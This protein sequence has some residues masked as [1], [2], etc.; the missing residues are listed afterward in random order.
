MALKRCRE[1]RKL[2]SSEA[3]VCPHCG[4]KTPV[5][6]SQ[7]SSRDVTAT[8][9][10]PA[11]RVLLWVAL[12]AG[13]LAVVLLAVRQ[14]DP[15]SE[16]DRAAIARRQADSVRV[17][18]LLTTRDRSAAQTIVLDRLRRGFLGPQNDSVHL[19]AVDA[20]LDSASRLLR[21]QP[22]SFPLLN[23]VRHLFGQLAQPLTTAQM[24]RLRQLQ[25]SER[26]ARAPLARQAERAAA[27]R[28]RQME[29]ATA[30]N[31]RRYARELEN[32]YLGQGL[33]VTVRA[34]AQNATTLRIT[35][36]LVSRPMAYQFSQS[37]T[38][39]SGLRSQGF[40]RLE[41]SDGYSQMWYWNL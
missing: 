21:Q 13:M 1:C 30:E 11:V 25:S 20:A 31:R 36:I 22:H 41:I 4:I 29:V 14:T 23:E 8:L 28:R 40:R 5:R 35:W 24:S 9:R 32:T 19:A 15:L 7:P 38:L 27:E 2:V 17:Q 6:P 39:F 37:P 12:V 16:S 3:E 10:R 18:V 34:S 33:D 26:S